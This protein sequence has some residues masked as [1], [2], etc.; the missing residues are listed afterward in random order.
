MRRRHTSGVHK[1]SESQ[2]RLS[3]N[4]RTGR[5]PQTRP[6]IMTKTLC[7]AQMHMETRSVV[8]DSIDTLIDVLNTQAFAEDQI[9]DTREH[10]HTS[11]L[12]CH[13]RTHFQKN[14]NFTNR[15]P[16]F[17]VGPLI[18]MPHP[19]LPWSLKLPNQKPRIAFHVA[20]SFRLSMIIFLRPCAPMFAQW[21]AS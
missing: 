15:C 10:A 4:E 6:N 7:I 19:L 9:E 18:T 14:S 1:I 5:R 8:E 20:E 12:G 16:S 3:I 17:P 2:T 13:C 11:N 21:S